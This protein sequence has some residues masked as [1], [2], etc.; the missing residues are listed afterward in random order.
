MC[1]RIVSS[2]SIHS[3]TTWDSKLLLL[4]SSQLPSKLFQWAVTINVLSARQLS[5]VPN[6][7]LVTCDHTQVI[8]PTNA[9][10]VETNLHAAIFYR[11]TSTNAMQTKSHPRAPP[12]VVAKAQHRPPERPLPNKHVTSVSNQAY[13]AT[14]VTLVQSASNARVGAPMSNSIVRPPQAGQATTSPVPH[15]FR[16]LSAVEGYQWTTSSLVLPP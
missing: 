12:M 10:T 11:D 9:S 5:L 15:P 4:Q 16:H 8:A 14:V 6:T 3:S 7:S 2:D 13:R 1:T